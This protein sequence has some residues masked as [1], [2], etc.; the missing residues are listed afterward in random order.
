MR[1]PLLSA[2]VILAVLVTG[3]AAA[4]DCSGTITTRRRWTP[5]ARATPH[6]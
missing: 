2:L 6:R 3:R 5:K 4:E 1:L